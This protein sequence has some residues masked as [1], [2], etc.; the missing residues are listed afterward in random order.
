MEP[1]AWVRTGTN[2]V[3]L[4]ITCDLDLHAA[5]G[6]VQAMQ[7]CQR[8]P[9]SIDMSRVGF[10]DSTGVYAFVQVLRSLAERGLTVR[11]VRLRAAVFEVLDLVGCVDAVGRQLFVVEE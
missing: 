5:D 3:E 7:R 10:V 9:V 2:D 4:V 1:V 6:V 8:G 11:A